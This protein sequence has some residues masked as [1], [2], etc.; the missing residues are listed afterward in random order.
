MTLTYKIIKDEE[1]REAI[2]ITD[3]VQNRRVIDKESIVSE[4]E[5]LQQL[6]KRFP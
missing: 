5:K 1:D 4:I 3:T 2:E 6:L